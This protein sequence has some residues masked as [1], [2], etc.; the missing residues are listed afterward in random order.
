MPGS[1]L[2][3]ANM[4]VAK[5]LPVMAISAGSAVATAA[6]AALLTDDAVSA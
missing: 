4:K 5:E 2:I 6:L 1:H 3:A